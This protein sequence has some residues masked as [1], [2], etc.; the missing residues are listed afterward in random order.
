MP[1]RSWQLNFAVVPGARARRL[2]GASQTGALSLGRARSLDTEV[3]DDALWEG[4]LYRDS[5]ATVALPLGPDYRPYNA[6]SA[7]RNPLAGCIT[8]NAPSLTVRSASGVITV[9]RRLAAPIRSGHDTIGEAEWK[10]L[11]LDAAKPLGVTRRTL[12]VA[13]N[14]RATI[15]PAMAYTGP[16]EGTTPPVGGGQVR[17]RNEGSFDGES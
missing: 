5:G 10:T 11:S 13:L 9:L 16:Q 3:A 2:R 6:G 4:V 14:E 8:R 7:P 17:R 1:V 12:S 15:H